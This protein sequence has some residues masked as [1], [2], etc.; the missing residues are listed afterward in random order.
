MNPLHSTSLSPDSG[1]EDLNFQSSPVNPSRYI[2][3]MS[4]DTNAQPM[5]IPM[6]YMVSQP[7]QAPMGYY[8]MPYAMPQMVP[9]PV[10]QMNQ[11]PQMA[12]VPMQQTPA[13]SVS[14]PELYVVESINPFIFPNKR[15]Y[16]QNDFATRGSI[17]LSLWSVAFLDREPRLAV[18]TLSERILTTNMLAELFSFIILKLIDIVSMSLVMIRPW[19]PRLTPKLPLPT[20]PP[21][22]AWY[23]QI[24][25]HKCI[26]KSS[27]SIPEI[28]FNHSLTSLASSCSLSWFAASSTSSSAFL[29]FFL[30]SRLVLSTSVATSVPPDALPTSLGSLSSL[31]SSLEPSVLLTSST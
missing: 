3:K 1:S 23:A 2:A 20:Q 13:H 8:A 10:E 31:L 24:F 5:F 4:Q 27:I 16:F 14:V 28:D 15:S 12:Y 21:F 22:S 17:L 25:T 9:M 19:S 6:Q 7:G 11:A 18:F 26:S 29:P 30:P